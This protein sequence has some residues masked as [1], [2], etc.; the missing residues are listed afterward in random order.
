M[1]FDYEPEPDFEHCPI[2]GT[3]LD[4]EEDDIGQD[5]NN[6]VRIFCPS[7]GWEAR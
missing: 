5:E 3:P 2:C 4:S 7:C 6:P 1:E